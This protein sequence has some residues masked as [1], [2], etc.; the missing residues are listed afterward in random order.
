[1]ASSKF[2]FDDFI[3][4]VDDNCKAFVTELHRE[5]TECGCKIEIKE[6]KSGFVVSYL[7]HKKTI[8]NYVFRKKGLI[9]RIYA[10]HINDYMPFLESLP[11]E[12]TNTMKEA[13]VC[14][15]YLDPS[16]CNQKCA[17]GYAYQL[18]GEWYQKCRNGAFMFLVNEQSKPFIRTFLHHEVKACDETN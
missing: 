18:H 7:L 13:P 3:A 6:A 12:M 11:A 15:R 14:K 16:S 1:M 4:T 5:L 8:A 17:M 2:G 10:N 9:V